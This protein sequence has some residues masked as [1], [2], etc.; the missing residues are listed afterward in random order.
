MSAA[1]SVVKSLVHRSLR[2]GLRRS[3]GS[4]SL[5]VLLYGCQFIG[6]VQVATAQA[7]FFLTANGVPVAIPKEVMLSPS[8]N[9]SLH[10]WLHTNRSGWSSRYDTT[11]RPDWCVHINLE[12]QNTTSLCRYKE[13]VVLRGLGP[14]IERSLGATDKAFFLQQIEVLNS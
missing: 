4:A 2:R 14:E 8:Q 5:L 10:D 3:A 7:R 13:R 6:P 1:P 11:T 12:K 9:Q